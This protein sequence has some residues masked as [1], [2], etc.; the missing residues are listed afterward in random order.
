MNPQRVVR[1]SIGLSPAMKAVS[2]ALGLV[3]AAMGGFFSLF[4]WLGVGVFEGRT[5]AVP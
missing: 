3:F 1:L 4:V 2:V 5:S